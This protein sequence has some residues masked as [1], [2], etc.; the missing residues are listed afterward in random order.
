MIHT[1]HEPQPVMPPLHQIACAIQPPRPE[2]VGDKPF[3]CQCRAVPV[4]P[5]HP[6]AAN[7]QFPVLMGG[8]GRSASSRT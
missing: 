2:W 8:T 7:E 4:A 6:V 3:F 5:R 1:S